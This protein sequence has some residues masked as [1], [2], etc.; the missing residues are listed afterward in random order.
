MKMERNFA[1]SVYL[2]LAFV[3]FVVLCIYS[4][5]FT[6]QYVFVMWETISFDASLNNS[7]EVYNKIKAAVGYFSYVGYRRWR[8]NSRQKTEF[9]LQT[10]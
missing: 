4:K 8:R 5:F 7:T 9:G 3:S 10:F 6:G 1:R 2:I